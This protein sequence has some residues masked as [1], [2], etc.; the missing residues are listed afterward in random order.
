MPVAYE[1]SGI[2]MGLN[3]FVENQK[4]ARPQPEAINQSKGKK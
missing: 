1:L 2:K 4:V 3:K